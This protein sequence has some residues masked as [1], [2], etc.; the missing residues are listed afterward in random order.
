KKEMLGYMGKVSGRDEDKIAKAGLTVSMKDGIP[1][2]EEAE[3]TLLCKKLYAGEIN[4]KDF[5]DE[6]IDS[7]INVQAIGNNDGTNFQLIKNVDGSTKVKVYVLDDSY[8]KKPYGGWGDLY[9]M[10][11]ETEGYVDQVENPYGGGT[12]YQTGYVARITPDG[13]VEFL[14]SA[15]R[16]V[17]IEGIKGRDFVDL[18]KVEEVLCQCE[19]VTEAYAYVYY[20]KDNGMHVGVDVTGDTGDTGVTEADVENIKAYA[21]EQLS[22][23][24]VPERIV[25]L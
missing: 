7:K 19:G 4:A 21:R 9:I 24:W 25:C 6:S 11:Y 1:V 15:G 16:T 14:E 8:Q 12:L 10:D 23:V 18:H 20:D 2:F 17:M 22:P 5:V 13:E 3:S